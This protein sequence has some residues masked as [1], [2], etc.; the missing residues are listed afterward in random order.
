METQLPCIRNNCGAPDSSYPNIKNKP[1][2]AAILKLYPLHQ[3]FFYVDYF[4]N[5]KLIVSWLTGEE[6]TRNTILNVPEYP[7]LWFESNYELQ[8]MAI[9]L[10]CSQGE[11]YHFLREIY[12]E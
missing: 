9:I 2:I 12:N 10:K 7:L 8:E 11:L 3:R 4:K 1:L 5:F 6:I